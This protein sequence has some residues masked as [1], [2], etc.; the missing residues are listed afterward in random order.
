MKIRRYQPKDS[1]VLAELFYNT[2]HFVNAKDYTK[3]Q[4]DVWANKD[5]NLDKWNQ[6]FLKHNTIVAIWEDSVV[7]FGDMDDTGYLDRLYVHKDYQG[8]GIATMI[9]DRLEQTYYG[10][11]I[12]THASITAKSF[13][14]KRGYQIVKQQQVKRNGIQLTNYIM[15]KTLE[16]IVLQK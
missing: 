11:T 5:I 13:F 14:E 7:G 2:V 6:S 12:T 15:K 3:E 9:C 16:N 4:L 1:K 10:Q 8:M